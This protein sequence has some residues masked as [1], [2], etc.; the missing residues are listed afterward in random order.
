VT[1]PEKAKGD[2]FERE[3]VAYLRTRGWPYAE[4]AFGAGRRD[5]Q[6]DILGLPGVVFQVKNHR[7][8]AFAEWVEQ[9]EEQR[10]RARAAFGAVIAKRRGKP[11]ADA[12]V[13][14]SLAVFLDLLR[15]VDAL[16]APT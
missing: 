14:V 3:V 10:A 2:A 13:V 5:D 1:S 15:E 8:H 6:G 16:K 11:V 9:A 12:Y 4:R 7:R